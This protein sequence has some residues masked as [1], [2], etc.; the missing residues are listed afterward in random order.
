MASMAEQL[1]IRNLLMVRP[2]LLTGYGVRRPV[3]PVPDGV[4]LFLLRAT[5]DELR[6]LMVELVGELA[7]RTSKAVQS[8]GSRVSPG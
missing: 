8:R 3:P 4:R 2:D 6:Q 5:S 7:E 1:A